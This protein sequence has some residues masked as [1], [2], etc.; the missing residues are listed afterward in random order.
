M[1]KERLIKFLTG[2]IA[3]MFAYAAIIKLSDYPKSRGE[4]LNQVFPAPMAEVLT[5]LIPAIEILLIVFLLVPAS[6]KK[7]IWASLSLMSAFTVYIILATNNV[8]GRI[9][10]S[11]SGILWDGAPYMAQ[12]IFNIL[13]IA[14]SLI[15][16]TIENGWAKN[17]T[18]FYIK[19]KK[20][21][22]SN[23]A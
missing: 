3:A 8:F 21:L 1:K 12:L 11:C 2:I 9:P 17:F 19:H 14:I 23:S 16:L 15:V 7:A 5:W 20:Q 10:C 13:F 6:R 18:W 22:V 4:M